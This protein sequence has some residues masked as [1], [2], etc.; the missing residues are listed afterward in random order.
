MFRSV[1]VEAAVRVESPLLAHRLEDALLHACKQRF[2]SRI[3]PSLGVCLTALRIC[4][5]VDGAGKQ[6]ALEIWPV[7]V[8]GGGLRARVHVE[9][10]LW[11]PLPHELAFAQVRSCS[12]FGIRLSILNGFDYAFVPPGSMPEPCTYHEEQRCWSWRFNEDDFVIGEGDWVRVLIERVEYATDSAMATFDSPGTVGSGPPLHILP[13]P[14]PVG[15]TVME[16]DQA[17]ATPGAHPEH[18][19]PLETEPPEF[20]E[21][22]S[23]LPLRVWARLDAPGLGPIDWWS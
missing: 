4:K 13:P 8:S 9:L 14:V 6:L 3:L 23:I 1:L 17:N 21:T 12:R 18:A 5:L 20:W 19:P 2:C 7:E 10:L 22:P 11:S 15:R 16:T